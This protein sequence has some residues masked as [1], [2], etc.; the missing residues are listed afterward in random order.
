[1]GHA[2]G[3]FVVFVDSDDLLLGSALRLYASLLEV[4]DGPRLM[5]AAFQAFRDKR[6]LA[7]ADA[8][9]GA[10]VIGNSPLISMRLRKAISL[11]R[12]G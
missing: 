11:E 2:S 8:S 6:E 1:M 10:P 9:A 5:L 4:K 12:I 7:T 3:R